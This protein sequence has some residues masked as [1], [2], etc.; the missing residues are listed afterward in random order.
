MVFYDTLEMKTK[1]L[2]MMHDKSVVQWIG[3]LLP[4]RVQLDL[5]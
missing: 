5:T 4:T 3:G 1:K 2:P